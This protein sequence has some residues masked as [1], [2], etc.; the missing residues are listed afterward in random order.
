MSLI[1][2]SQ[3]KGN[4]MSIQPT[5]LPFPSLFTVFLAVA[6]CSCIRLMT[7]GTWVVSPG[8]Q[9]GSMRGPAQWIPTCESGTHSCWTLSVGTSG[10]V[11]GP[12]EERSGK[13]SLKL[14]SNQPQ[15]CPLCV[16]SQQDLP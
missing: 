9:L 5:S 15:I 4:W 14:S 12:V 6:S 11:S 13:P 3:E 16:R 1:G 7:R 8:P 10:E 2:I